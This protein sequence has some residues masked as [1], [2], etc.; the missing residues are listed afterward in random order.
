MDQVR[1]CIHENCKIVPSFAKTVS[2]KAEYCKNH[3]PETYI[4]VRSK[5]CSFPN[6]NIILSSSNLINKNFCTTHY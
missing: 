2:N 6:C 1:K 3:A 5:I 4:S